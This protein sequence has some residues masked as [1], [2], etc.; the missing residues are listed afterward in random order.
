MRVRTLG[1]AVL[2]LTF[3]TLLEAPKTLTQTPSVRR[4]PPQKAVIASPAAERPGFKGILEPVNYGNDIKF[5]D[6]FFTG[7]DE[8]WVSG[9][10]ATILHTADAGKTWSAEVG[11]D[12]AN[13]EH[14]IRSLRFL[15]AKL[16]WA[17]QS[18]PDRL[19]R[20]TDGQ[21]WQELGPIPRG[22]QDYTFTSASHGIVLAN[23]SMNYYRGGVFLTEDSGKTWKPLMECT[24]STTVNAL[25]HTE[26]CWF[27]RLEMLSHRTGY[28]LA[29]DN[30]N[31]LAFFHT[32]DAGR[33]WNYRALPID[34]AGCK[35][36]DFFF[37]DANHGVLVFKEGKTYVT[38]DG[39]N[40]T[41]MLATTLGPQIRFADP[42]IGWTLWSSPSNW[43]AAR[44]SY[45]TDGGQHWKASADIDLPLHNGA[46]YKF[47][48]PRRDRA[49]IIGNHGMVYRYSMVPQTY[50]APN[51][52]AA[53]LMPSFDTSA[54]TAAASRVSKDIA[55]LQPQIA[56][57]A[58]GNA[59]SVVATEANS[60]SGGFTQDTAP[61]PALPAQATPNTVDFG[62]TG[63]TQ[64]VDASPASAPL[65][66]CCG[67]TLRNLQS[68]LTNF[69]QAA[70]LATSQFRSLNLVIAGFQVVTN[71]LNQAQQLRTAFSNLK[72]APNL[73][74]ASA[75]L[76]QLST[77]ANFTQQTASTG[78]QNPGTWY[79]TP[80]AAGGFVQDVGT[81]VNP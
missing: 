21:N 75:A 29:C 30:N 5:T 66:Q 50:T 37:T 45:T 42:Q 52:F 72:H 53:P 59:S 34:A 17:I 35:E 63:F 64:D 36:A 27:V 1:F 7:A 57:A 77:H 51:S 12:P 20:T 16:G 40:W 3:A 76:Q 56:A 11:G 55:Q 25:A 4:T 31:S 43:R 61:A 78:F 28:A 81:P 71:L 65:Q 80:A 73:Q 58:T 18:D 60:A 48:F 38:N 67:P 14:P 22:V 32:D 68:D 26:S 6:A 15:S 33:S 24:M 74:A 19:L 62:S 39:S 54:L 79:A 10:H 2:S 69:N 8:G 49:Y 41:A 44:I 9:E 13:S 70:P 47:A 23:G 46:E